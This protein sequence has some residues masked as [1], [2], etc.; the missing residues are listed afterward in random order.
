MPLEPWIGLKQ[1]SRDFVERV[2]RIQ[3]LADAILIADVKDQERLKLSTVFSAALLKEKLGVEAIPVITARDS[4]RQ[5]IRS[6]ILTSFSWGLDTLM[7]AWGDRYPRDA[8]IRN[9][10]DYESLAQ[11]IAEAE[12]LAKRSGVRATFLAPVD[13]SR[14]RS[15]EGRALAR[16]RLKSG[17][18]HLLAQ[19]PTTDSFSTL[20]SHLRILRRQGLGSK[21]LLNVFPFRS[22]IDVSNCRKKFGWDLPRELDA[23]AKKGEPE[24]LKE[25]RRV[26]AR[27][28]ETDATG[29]YV[30]T[31]GQPE[32]ARY[33]L[34]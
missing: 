22:P 3:S 17:A 8:G 11:L 32:V 14:L 30:S 25:A 20:P 29:V 6:A 23:L 7:F 10:Y 15:P 27:I 24:L 13:I 4:N 18:T 5:M 1:K 12:S 16:K 28:I 31:R 2:R 34:A 21:V 26:A 19:P 9:V 33:I